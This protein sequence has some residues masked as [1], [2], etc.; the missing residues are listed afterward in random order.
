ALLA[1]TIHLEPQRTSLPLRPG[2]SRPHAARLCLHRLSAWSRSERA[3]PSVPG[4]RGHR[5]LGF[6]C[7]DYPLRAAANEPTPP[8]RA[9]AATRRSALLAPTI[10]LEPQR[11]S[12]PLRPGPSRPQAAR[13]CL[14][15][16]ST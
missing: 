15:R 12:L 10:R 14:H 11:T 2:P 6:A 16:L 13:L 9:V 8:S 7:T 1:P 5:P 4:R 3:Y